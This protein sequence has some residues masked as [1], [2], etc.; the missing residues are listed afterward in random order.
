MK[1]H[2]STYFRFTFCGH[3]VVDVLAGS[4]I[5]PFPKLGNCPKVAS[6]SPSRNA[7]TG[8]NGLLTPPKAPVGIAQA[9]IFGYALRKST[10]GLGSAD[11]P[12]PERITVFGVGRY[13]IP[14]RGRNCPEPASAYV[15]TGTTPTPP[16]YTFPSFASK[17][18]TPPWSVWGHGYNSHRT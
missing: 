11:R 10:Y 6:L 13:A 7:V 15:S 8:T 17:R 5:T 16:M 3:V 9:L 4:L 2:D 12:N 1:F 14:M 18:G